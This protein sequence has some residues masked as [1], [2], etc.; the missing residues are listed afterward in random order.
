MPQVQIT[1]DD[2]D[3]WDQKQ[4]QVDDIIEEATGNRGYPS[5][6]SVPPTIFGVDLSQDAIDKLKALGGVSISVQE[7]E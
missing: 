1:F 5:T 4:S 2:P 6:N 3:A 7:G